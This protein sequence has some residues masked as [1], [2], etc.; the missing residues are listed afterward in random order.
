M[1]PAIRL[2][3]SFMCHVFVNDVWP[4][5]VGEMVCGPLFR[6]LLA[7]PFWAAAS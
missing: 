2:P 1:A 5:S 6:N 3:A 7:K 4:L